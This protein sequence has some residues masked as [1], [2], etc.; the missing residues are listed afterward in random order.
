VD[1]Y[2][3]DQVF[4]ESSLSPPLFVL[5]LTISSQRDH[6]AAFTSRHLTQ[7]LSQLIAI[8]HRQSD[9]QNGTVRLELRGNIQSS[10]RVMGDRDLVTAILQSDLKQLSR[11]HIVI[12]D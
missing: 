7:P 1:R 8:D 12:H 9:V 6:P 5:F 4:F 11:V 3:L 2:G 10:Q